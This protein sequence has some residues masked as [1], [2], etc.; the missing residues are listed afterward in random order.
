MDSELWFDKLLVR[1]EMINLMKMIV[2]VK[3]KKFF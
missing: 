3:L 1:G 2:F